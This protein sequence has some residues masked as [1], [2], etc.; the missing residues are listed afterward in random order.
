MKKFSI[1]LLSIFLAS[2]VSV[3][4]DDLWDN[5]GDSNVYGQKAVSEEDF[6]KALESKK[7][8]R[9]ISP[10][11]K[12]L[13][14]KM[15]KNTNKNTPQGESYSQSNETEIISNTKAE[16]PVLM[17]PLPLKVNDNY[18]IPIGHYQVEGEKTDS[19]EVYIK[20]YQ[21]HDLIAKIPAKETEQD[22]EDES[23]NFVK[24]EPHGDNHVEII[25]GCL[26]FNAFA[27]IDIE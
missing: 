21:A 19:G 24:L 2:S 15:K 13:F 17:I 16:L 3:Y 22:Y 11:G 4:A 5:F 26:D 7:N 18:I 10:F 25:F 27:I 1:L 12:T 9:N 8:K 23:I 20:L 6:Q 14:E